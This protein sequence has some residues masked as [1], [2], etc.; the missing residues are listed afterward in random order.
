M[1]FINLDVLSQKGKWSFD[2]K[3]LI[4][5][6]KHLHNKKIPLNIKSLENDK[7]DKISKALKN[8]LDHEIPPNKLFLSSKKKFGSWDNAL[9]ASGLNPKLIRKDRKFWTR[10][11][12][13]ESVEKQQ[14]Y[15]LFEQIKQS[16]SSNQALI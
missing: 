6:I 10:E 14:G 4:R 12:M 7:N 13:I 15:S 1:V 9:K 5:T 11:M 2:E 8:Y 3:T 16:H